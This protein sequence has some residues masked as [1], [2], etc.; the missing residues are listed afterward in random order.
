[1]QASV[2]ELLTRFCRKNGST[3]NLNSLIAPSNVHLKEALSINDRG[4]IVGKA[5]LPNGDIHQ[6]LLIPNDNSND[7]SNA[8]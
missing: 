4:E 2:M 3:M 7:N 1:M 8:D 5:V 6:Y